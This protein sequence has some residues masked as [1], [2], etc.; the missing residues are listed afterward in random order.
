M[1]IPTAIAFHNKIG[2]AA[3]EARLRLPQKPLGRTRPKN[4]R[5]H[6]AHA[7][8]SEDGRGADLIPS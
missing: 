2:T 4:E 8:R 7:G 3:K 6:R 5:A 1:T